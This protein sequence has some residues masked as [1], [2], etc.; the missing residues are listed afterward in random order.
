MREREEERTTIVNPH[1][2]C[3]ECQLLWVPRPPRSTR[4]CGVP[5]TNKY[6]SK[7]N[8]RTFLQITVLC[9]GYKREGAREGAREGGR[10]G[11]REGC[12]KGGIMMRSG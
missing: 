4:R 10:E 2:Q 12:E 1:Q 6:R 9:Q 5:A 8:S 11:G 7:G 3:I